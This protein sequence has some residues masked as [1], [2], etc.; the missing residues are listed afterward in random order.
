MERSFLEL[1]GID[2]I[3]DKEHVAL[4]ARDFNLLSTRDHSQNNK[5]S[6]LSCDFCQEIT[7]VF[8]QEITGLVLSDL[9][10]FNQSLQEILKVFF[11]AGSKAFAPFKQSV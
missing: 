10:F 6:I 9:S 11:L 8:Q 4:F 5:V 7:F 1:F 2:K 3:P